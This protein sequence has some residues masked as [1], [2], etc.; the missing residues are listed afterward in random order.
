M[1]AKVKTTLFNL[2]FSFLTCAFFVFSPSIN[3]SATNYDSGIQ[4]HQII[5][6]N[7]RNTNEKT[8]KIDLGDRQY[9]ESVLCSVYTSDGKIAKDISLVWIS[10][11]CKNIF[12]EAIRIKLMSILQE[13]Y[14]IWHRAR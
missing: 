9:N 11:T 1:L 10:K 14:N 2:L 4:N 7:N 3:C 13:K 8:W 12:I 6:I 5:K